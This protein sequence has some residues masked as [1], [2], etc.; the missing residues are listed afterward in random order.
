MRLT[1]AAI[2]GAAV[3][4]LALAQQ[5]SVQSGDAQA[6]AAAGRGRGGGGFTQPV[7]ADWNN[8]EGWTQIFDG[9][10]LDNYQ[11]CGRPIVSFRCLLR[12]PD[13]V[14]PKWIDGQPTNS[15][16]LDKGNWSA[17]APSVY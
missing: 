2:V 10:S 12:L 8:H 6:Q 13:S 5:T 4:L 1:Q 14:S 17:I 9:K 3:S 11:R 15:P 16:E 7:P